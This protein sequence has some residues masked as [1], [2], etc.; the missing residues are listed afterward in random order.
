MMSRVMYFTLFMCAVST[1]DSERQFYCLQDELNTECLQ[2]HTSGCVLRGIKSILSSGSEYRQ[3]EM[4]NASMT[5]AP[6]P[7]SA[8][9]DCR[10]VTTKNDDNF[11]EVNPINLMAYASR[12]QKSG[13]DILHHLSD[14]SSCSG[15]NQ[16]SD[17]PTK[18]NCPID[19]AVSTPRAQSQF[20]ERL[21]SNDPVNLAAYTRKQ[22]D[23]SASSSL[24]VNQMSDVSVRSS[25]DASQPST[26][27]PHSAVQT[28]STNAKDQGTLSASVQPPGVYQGT[29]ALISTL[30]AATSA[31]TQQTGAYPHSLGFTQNVPPSYH[32]AQWRPVL[33]PRTAQLVAN[34][35][36]TSV[37]PLR[38]D[39][40]LKEGERNPLLL[41]LQ[42]CCR[43]F[44]IYI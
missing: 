1:D 19:L 14:M 7:L 8:A 20:S 4:Q 32:S 24:P 13:S 21:T 44:V 15:Y 22:P 41:Q 30:S 38:A 18:S 28:V 11:S 31:L 40:A 34:A 16:N 5:L 36:S 29:P 23:Y 27:L 37:Q 35:V 43:L 12:A 3:T 9:S 2:W 10:T 39:N 42:V 26:S 33:S 25:V 17:S 6:V